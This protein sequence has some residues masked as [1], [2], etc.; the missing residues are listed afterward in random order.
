MSRCST[1]WHT[2]VRLY[3]RVKK[4]FRIQGF[5]YPLRSLFFIF[6]WTYGMGKIREDKQFC[7]LFRHYCFEKL[8]V[9]GRSLCL[10]EICI[11]LEKHWLIL[12][13][14]SINHYLLFDRQSWFPIIPFGITKNCVLR[15][16]RCSKQRK[17]RM[18]K[19]HKN[20]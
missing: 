12:H 2:S 5:L 19:I 3:L 15:S 4:Y 20:Y 6:G 10:I 13:S 8:V 7:R 16:N 11:N 14:F 17:W 9:Y 18:Y 1:I